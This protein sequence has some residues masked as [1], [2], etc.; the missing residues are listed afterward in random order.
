MHPPAA[1]IRQPVSTAET[2]AVLQAALVA[3]I[4]VCSEPVQGLAGVGDALRDALPVGSVSYVRAAMAAARLQEPESLSYP[5]CL[6][7]LLLRDVRSS[8]AG[9]VLGR[10]FVKPQRTKAFTGFVFDTMD[11][12][13]RLAEHDRLQHAAFLALPPEERV[14]ISEPV[15]FMCEWRYYVA[16][17]KVAGGARYDQDGADDARAPDQT[18]LDGAVHAMS[19][20]GHFTYAIDLGVLSTGETALVEANDAWALGLYGRALSPKNYLAMLW[21]RWR[22]IVGG[23]APC[24]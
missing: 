19:A 16:G 18:V 14:W 10:W 12:P 15:H 7:H 4:P 2:R 5:D 21:T 23:Q 8:R 11:D 1:I 6:R 20:G 24:R 13:G 9:S 22:E 3:D 17:G